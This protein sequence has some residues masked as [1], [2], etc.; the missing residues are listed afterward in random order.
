MTDYRFAENTKVPVAKTQEEMKSWLRRAGADQ[1]AVYEAS[2]KS[3]VAFRIG[4]R[5]Y[6]LTVPASK[7]SN[8]AQAER[9][10]WRLL[11]LVVRAKLEAAKAGLTTIEHEFMADTVMPN[12]ATMGEWAAPQI[13]EAYRVGAMPASLMI[14]GPR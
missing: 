4:G 9:A 2:D 5:F 3:S 13:A 6:R 11:L 12:G 10:A 14:E 8:A 1:L 7:A